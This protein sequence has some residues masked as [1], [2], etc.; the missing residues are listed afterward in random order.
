[1]SYEGTG[2]Y[3]ETTLIL[4]NGVVLYKVISCIWCVYMQLFGQDTGDVM[5][6]SVH[7]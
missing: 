5:Q 4:F 2:L 7:L 6:C 3:Q 1:M